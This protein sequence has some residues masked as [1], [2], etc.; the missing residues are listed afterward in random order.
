M[1]LSLIL[2]FAAILAMGTVGVTMALFQGA[3]DLFMTVG[4][5]P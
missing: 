4:E 5:A 1:R 3:N 2:L